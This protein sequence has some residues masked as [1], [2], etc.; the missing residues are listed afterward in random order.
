VGLI[1][2]KKLAAN[3]GDCERIVRL[4]NAIGNANI[5]N[6]SIGLTDELRVTY[7]IG[8]GIF[9]R[10]HKTLIDSYGNVIA[11]THE[12][13][14]VRQL[15]IAKILQS[16]IILP[17]FDFKEWLIEEGFAVGIHGF[18]HRPQIGEE[19]IIAF[20]FL[21]EDEFDVILVCGTNTDLQKYDF[22]LFNPQS[23]QEAETL[24]KLLGLSTRKE[25]TK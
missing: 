20:A 17:P 12:A 4:A 15:E 3:K 10:E 16:Y 13:P 24:F 14:K 7:V 1:D 8:R 25:E 11:T 6:F 23:K 18:Y 19:D 21:Y 22:P 5:D 9:E 2:L